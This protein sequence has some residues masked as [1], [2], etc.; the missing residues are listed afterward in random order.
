MCVCHTRASTDSSVWCRD[1]NCT[2]V[3][4]EIGSNKARVLE[5]TSRSDPTPFLRSCNGSLASTRRRSR[6]ALVLQREQSRFRA[7]TAL[8]PRRVQPGLAMRDAHAH[9]FFSFS[10]LFSPPPPHTLCIWLR[11]YTPLQGWAW[12]DVRAALVGRSAQRQ[13]D[14]SFAKAQGEK[15]QAPSV[16]IAGRGGAARAGEEEVGG[17]RH[18]DAYMYCMHAPSLTRQSSLVVAEGRTAGERWRSC[19]GGRSSA[20]RRL[21]GKAIS[22]AFLPRHWTRRR[23]RRRG[24]RRFS[25]RGGVCVCLGKVTT[26]LGEGRL[27]I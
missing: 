9:P 13:R 19:K 10:F 1:L 4:R 15:A 12:N 27:G 2:Q 14:D 22:W 3:V 6:R 7:S 25:S 5:E 26:R 20:G 11:A 8:M 24:G 17:A 23:R 16:G 21:L 18:V